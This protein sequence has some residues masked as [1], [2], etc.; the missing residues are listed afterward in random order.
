MKLKVSKEHFSMFNKV[1]TSTLNN[2]NLVQG[3]NTWTVSLLRYSAAFISWRKCELQ[4]ADRT[5]RKF[6]TIYGGLHSK[7]DVD[8]LYVPRKV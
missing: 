3:I 2:G 1:L 5:T 4:V 8:K 6:F 7:S